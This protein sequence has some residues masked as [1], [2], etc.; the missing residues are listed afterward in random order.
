M[1]EGRIV[2]LGKIADDK[3][4][5][6]FADYVSIDG[7]A[8]RLSKELVARRN[9]L[10]ELLADIDA[11]IAPF[12]R[13]IERFEALERAEAEV[14]QLAEQVNKLA[15]EGKLANANIIENVRRHSE[16]ETELRERQKALFGLL[17]RKE[18]TIQKDLHA[19]KSGHAA[20][21]EKEAQIRGVYV[22]ARRRYEALASQRDEQRLSLSSINRISI[23]SEHKR[24]SS[25]RENALTELQETDAKIAALRDSIVK[26][27]RI[28]GA[29]CTKAYMAVSEIGAVDVV[30]IDE[31]SMVLLPVAWFA[32]G[33]AKERTIVCG[34]FRQIPPIIQS[35]QE[36]IVEAI[37]K[38]AFTANGGSKNDRLSRLE[39][40][41]RMSP[42]ICGLISRPMYSGRL[43]TADEWRP[44]P[45]TLPSPFDS[46]L[47]IIDTSELW[48]FESQNAH[49]SR[50]NLMHALLTRNLA[51]HLNRVGALRNRETLG[52]CTPYSA[53]AKLI[54]NLLEGE[55]LGHLVEVGTVH[56]Y[57]GDERNS[58][59]IEIPE[60]HGSARSIGQFVQGIPPE[61]TGARLINVAVSRAKDRLFVMANLTY[62]DQKLPSSSLLRTILHKMQEGGR[63]VPATELLKLRPI[64]SDLQGLIGQMPFEEITET[65]GLFDEA[66]FERALMHDIAEAQSSIVIFS[67]YVTPQRVSKLGDVLRARVATGVRV[68]CI[69][70]PPQTNGSIPHD[71]SRDALDSLEKIGVT[72]D[73]RA[74][75][76]QKV[77]LIDNRIVWYGSLNALSHAGRS[78]ET[79][80]RLVN[81]N[82][83]QMVAGH[84]SKRR[85]SADQ[86]SAGAAMAENPR[87]ADCRSR[88]TYKEGRLGPYFECENECGWRRSVDK[89]DSGPRQSSESLARETGLPKAGGPC[90]ICGSVTTLFPG[91]YGPF[92][93]CSQFRST[94]C[95]G[96]LKPPK[97]PKKRSAKRAARKN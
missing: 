23:E 58:M 90:P 30:I 16:L 55:G 39:V 77:C 18:E 84:M 86:A 29:T 51:W 70:R 62:L 82:F 75:I 22:S 8:E 38:D 78:D 63:I 4:A 17:L 64:H 87:C 96:A 2:R 71:Q 20:L 37:G 52:V 3:L 5:D 45:A 68:R 33:L 61:S 85:Q 13:T 83:A 69:T 50:F 73:C 24:L 92:Y 46:D 44:N 40:Q 28:L 43:K 34:D 14:T 79:M 21:Q 97:P 27:A 19:V 94:G 60:S 57:Q 49:F 67:G 25:E 56:R 11:R 66:S 36:A 95:K 35:E 89:I 76:H 1:R 12:R 53:Q 32:A 9:Q 6:K 91:K 59:L 54:R 65:L 15:Q 42:S 7:I 93:G 88:T 41:H 47:T 31:A 48:P 81:A 72:V 10:Q 74:R 80:T 26:N